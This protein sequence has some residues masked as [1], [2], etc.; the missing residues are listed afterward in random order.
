MVARHEE[1]GSKDRL[2]ERC[3]PQ[4]MY[5]SLP[6]RTA[7]CRAVP[8]RAVPCRA[9]PCRCRRRCCC[10]CCLLQS[11]ASLS[12][13]AAATSIA[14]SC[15]PLGIFF[16]FFFNLV[17]WGWSLVSTVGGSRHKGG[18][19]SL[20]RRPL[21]V[22]ADLCLRVFA[23]SAF[24]SSRKRGTGLGEVPD[25]FESVSFFFVF[26][27]FPPFFLL[28]FFCSCLF[29]SLLLLL[30][31][32]LPRLFFSL[33]PPPFSLSFLLVLPLSLSSCL[34]RVWCSSV[35]LKFSFCMFD[36]LFMV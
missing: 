27:F 24:P 8:C 7:S 14:L 23:L 18:W 15:L 20:P 33:S 29:L 28:S 11:A 6:H 26:F 25:S 3:T 21:S 32:S 13:V 36:I 4:D 31:L 1:V 2:K 5:L 16:F 9:V 17:W 10:C 19:I 34:L 12:S 22:V 30:S 35:M